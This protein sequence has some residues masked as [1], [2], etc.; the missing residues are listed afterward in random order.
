[1]TTNNP[2]VKD[3]DIWTVFVDGASSS[4]GSGAEI[5]LENC[6]GLIVEVSLILSFP[7][8]NK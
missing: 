3:D 6:E 1:M 5:I 2:Q 7:T 8:L 4:S